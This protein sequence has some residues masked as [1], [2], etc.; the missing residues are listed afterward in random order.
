M[1][2]PSSEDAAANRGPNAAVWQLELE[3][4]VAQQQ[5]FE[6]EARFK[7][8]AAGR[9]F[10]KTLLA[11]AKAIEVAASKPDA[12]VWWVSPSHDQSRMALRMVAKAIPQ[13]HRE[14]NKT[15]SEIYLSNGGRIAFKS[16]ER[17]D[18]LRGE[19]L[20]LVIVDEAAFV[21]ESLWTQAIRPTLSDKNGK[22]LLIS[23]FD[24]E[25]WF[26]DLYRFA[27]D[28]RNEQW[29]GWRFPTS[30]N[31][32]IPA[33]EIAEAQRN[34]PKEV[35]GQEYLA[36]PLAFAGAVFDGDKLDLAYKA[37]QAFEAPARGMCEAGL[38]WGWN[39]TVLEVC[40]ELPDG[41]ISWIAE[42]VLERTEL[43]V[44]CGIIAAYCIQYGIETIYA[45]AAGADEN[46]TLAK[47]LEARNCPTFVQPV[48]FNAYKR[49]GVMTRVFYL[50]SDR[51]I[52]TPN[53][54]QLV[55]DSKAYHYDPKA[56]AGDEKFAKGHDHSV[57]AVTAFYASRSYVL[58]DE[59]G[60]SG[61]DAA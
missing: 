59:P 19:G 56:A 43:T 45:D 30:S 5:V 35:F 49:T 26:Y 52:L 21:S 54:P 48:P 46:V 1:S 32:Y 7:V 31:P 38:D 36:S 12:V 28:P 13:R 55:I 2:R 4:H 9:R 57:D 23:T 18:N 17:S 51:E 29:E 39:F 22:A 25:N 50:E 37:G 6:S 24:G 47:I 27:L 33:E 53:C 40:Q 10:G 11:A 3:L 14:V 42:E 44:K 8:I 60:E 16:G 20:D 41:R 58:G 61:E 34:L 15:L